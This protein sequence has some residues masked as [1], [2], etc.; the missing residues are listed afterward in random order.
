MRRSVVAAAFL[1]L[2]GAPTFGAD[3]APPSRTRVFL[4]SDEAILNPERGFYYWIDLV[5]GRDFRYLRANGDT[6]GFASVSLAAYRTSPIESSFLARLWAG[7]D[8]VRASG[9]KVILR[10]KYSERPGDPDAPKEWILTHIRQ[11]APVLQAHSDVIAVLQ[12]GFIGA[13]GEWHSSTY[14]LTNPADES[15]ILRALLA[16]FP[17]QRSIQVRKPIHKQQALGYA[18]LSPAEA[19]SESDRARVGHHNDAF[20]SNETDGGTYPIPAEPHKEWVAAESRYVPVGG[21][22]NRLNPPMTDGPHADWHLTRFRF[23]FLSRQYQRSVIDG[24]RQTGWLD[25]FRRKLGYRL[26][27]LEA[28]WPDAVRPGGILEFS[29]RVRNDGY[30]PPFNRRPV[31]LVLANDAVWHPC[32]LWWVDVRTWDG[33]GREAFFTARLRVPATVSPG[34]YRLSLWF[35]DAALS[36]QYRPE[37]AIRLANA[38]LWDPASGYNVLT[39]NLVVDPGAPGSADPSATTFGEA[40]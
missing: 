23:S 29:A 24:W 32:R 13:W 39:R 38:G 27:L 15:D 6:L 1:F 14:G 9:I 12:A 36:L 22:C 10:F 18:P 11:L 3:E 26:R 33:G 7:L 37:Y 19:F 4:P 8:A 40:P 16:V 35:P 30:A 20:L 5:N 31:Y 2:V 17:R 34:R 28:S 21:E 25:V